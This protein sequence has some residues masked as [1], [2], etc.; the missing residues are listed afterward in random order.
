MLEVAYLFNAG[1]SV[2]QAYERCY[3]DQALLIVQPERI[4]FQKRY[5]R[6]YNRSKGLF[7][8][9]IQLVLNR[10]VAPSPSLSCHPGEN[11]NKRFFLSASCH[12]HLVVR[13]MHKN[14]IQGVVFELRKPFRAER[15]AST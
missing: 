15:K 3:K 9:A 13:S 6:E 12:T 7:Q 10:I 5:Y 14:G 8:S 4:I 1:P 11:A 2:E